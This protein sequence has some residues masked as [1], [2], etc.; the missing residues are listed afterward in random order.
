MAEIQTTHRRVVLVHTDWDTS[1]RVVRTAKELDLFNGDNIWILL[2][3]MLEDRR[4]TS[5]FESGVFREVGDEEEDEYDDD[6]ETEE[7]FDHDRD[8]NGGGKEDGGNDDG[9]DND[10]ERGPV[11]LPNGMLAL[12]NKRRPIY[13]SNLLDSIVELAGKAALNTYRNQLYYAHFRPPSSAASQAQSSNRSPFTQFRPPSA[14]SSSSSSTSPSS[15]LSSSLPSATPQSPFVSSSSSSPFSSASIGGCQIKAS[16]ANDSSTV[17][18]RELR[19][20]ILR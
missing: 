19:L 4:Q 3:G 8:N 1:Q 7:D 15:S 12:R 10:D 9:T 2:D 20:S 6:E 17:E 14:S 16:T 11:S 13:D 5:I 18:E